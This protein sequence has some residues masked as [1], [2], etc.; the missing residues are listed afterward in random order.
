MEIEHQNRLSSCAW[1]SWRLALFCLSKLPYT[2]LKFTPWLSVFSTGCCPCFP[3]FSDYC[4][5]CRTYHQIVLQIFLTVQNFC[6]QFEQEFNII[7]RHYSVRKLTLLLILLICN[8]NWLWL[9]Q[10]NTFL[11][12]GSIGFDFL[13][14][15][16]L[17]DMGGGGVLG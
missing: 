4:S 5:L 11:V 2:S 15:R 7:S 10:T 14:R 8:F 3:H 9:I 1:F 13:L 6:P 17:K 16:T 12:L